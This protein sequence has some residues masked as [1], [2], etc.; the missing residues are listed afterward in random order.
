MKH[1]NF[2][3]IAAGLGIII[4]L[5]LMLG[6]ATEPAGHTRL[7][8]LMLLF[9]SEFGFLITA[10]GTIVSVRGWQRTRGRRELLLGLACG[11]LALGFVAIGL[12]IWRV[13]TG[14]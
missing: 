4:S 14:T 12:L 5:A 13:H 3:W 2:P 10:A 11:V 8:T 7:P 1:F 6:G 9:M